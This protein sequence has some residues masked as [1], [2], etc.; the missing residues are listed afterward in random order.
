VEGGAEV[1]VAVLVGHV[2]VDGQL[3]VVQGVVVL[4]ILLALLT[5]LHYQE[6]QVLAV[7]YSALNE[8]ALGVVVVV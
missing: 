4:V 5:A 8:E 6:V 2:G 1:E 7:G 3:L